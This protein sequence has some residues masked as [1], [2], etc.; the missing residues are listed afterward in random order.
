MSAPRLLSVALVLFASLAQAETPAGF[1][2]W[3]KDIAALEAKQKEQPAAPGSLLF[4][5]SS[6]IRMWD[7]G[8]S[9][10]EENTVNQGFGGSML[11]DTVHFFDRLVVPPRP[12]AVIVYAGDNDIA[13]GH[14]AEEVVADFKALVSRCEEKLSGVPLVYVAIKPSVRRWELWPEMERAN[15]AIAA[16]CGSKGHLHYA[17]IATPMLAEAEGAPGA[18][19]FLKDGLH[20]S[21]MG[22]ARW[23]E[24]V[25][26][27]LREAGV[28]R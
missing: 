21:P 27:A 3:E 6:S 8:A 28:L 9:W 12:R 26:A 20:L 5:G 19:W 4:V 7:L 2:R 13:K 23:T 22:Y 18:E 25:G 24:I 14:S 15:E 17:D 16:I 1:A 10:P 11:S